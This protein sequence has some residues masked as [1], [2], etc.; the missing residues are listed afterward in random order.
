[1]HLIRFL[2]LSTLALCGATLAASETTQLIG[3]RH[4]FTGVYPADCAPVH[5]GTRWTTSW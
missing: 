2:T 4:D 3:Y 1:M 5:A